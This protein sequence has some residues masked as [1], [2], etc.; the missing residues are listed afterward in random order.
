MA[1][2]GSIYRN[3]DEVSFATDIMPTMAGISDPGIP[4]LVGLLILRK[5]PEGERQ[6]GW[7]GIMDPWIASPRGFD[8]GPSFLG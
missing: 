2:F 7:N 5:E 3:D 8:F 6:R 4:I 1:D